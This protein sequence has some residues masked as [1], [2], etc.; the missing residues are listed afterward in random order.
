MIAR[1]LVSTVVALSIAG[2]ALAQAPAAATDNPADPHDWFT[3]EHADAELLILGMFHFKDAGHDTYKP[4]VDVDILSER[5]QAELA[6]LLDRLAAFAPTK[7]LIEVGFDR[8]AEFEERYH[9]YLAGE[10]EITANE[11]YQVG[12]R[13]AQRLGHQRLYAVDADG[14][15]Y[16]GLP[17]DVAAYAAEHGQAG[18][19]ESPWDE[20]YTALYRADDHAKAGQTLIE[21]LLYLNSPE[22]LRIGHGHYVLRSIALGT[23][24]EYPG[25]DQL[26]GWWYN[27]NLRIFANVAR[28]TESGDRL[29]L[30]I[31]AGHVPIL[32]HAAD[33]SPELHLVDVAT[34]LS[35]GPR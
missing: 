13:L 21:H 3:A 18:L 26:T 15:S 10:F 24:T 28:V 22:R 8:Q 35:S 12:F 33:A 34:V 30:L 2:A 19:L 27:R 31:G 5:R 29:L 25:A 6:E 17:E 1:L 4:E 20:R 9:D 14:R 32:R 23:A 16:P 7:I 11:I